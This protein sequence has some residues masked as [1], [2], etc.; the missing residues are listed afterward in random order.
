MSY[1][2]GT[3]LGQHLLFPRTL[4]EYID[5]ANPVRAIGAFSAALDFRA[6]QFVRAAATAGPVS[7]GPSE[8]G[9]HVAETG[10]GMRAQPG[11]DL[12]DEKSATGL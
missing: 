10:A 5:E 3:E 6:L 4:D 1:I 9:A 8:S 12:A 7:V 11:T 2:N